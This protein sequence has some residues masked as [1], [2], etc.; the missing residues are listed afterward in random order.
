[1]VVGELT[2]ERDLVILGGGPAGYT[3]AIRASQ[4]GRN[5]TLIEQAQ[6]GGLC[7]NKGCIPSKVVAHAAD[8]K[9]QMKHM[10]ALGFSFNPTHD[11]SQLVEYRERTIRQLR[12]G[13]EALCQA[14]SIEIIQGASSFL[15][16]D[17]IGVELG[18]QFDTYR[19]NDVVIATG[20]HSIEQDH[21]SV[22]NAEQL[23]QLTKLPERLVIIG[24]DY[25]AL[26]AAMSFQALGTSVTL[27]A[28]DFG[29][30]PSLDKELRRLLK[31]QK[32]QLVTGTVTAIE[33]DD[34]VTV[35]VVKQGQET[36]WS[37]PFL[38]QSLPRVPHT[39]ELGLERIGV[40]L[41]EDGTIPVDPFGQTNRPHI[42]AIGDV[43]P[44]P[45]IATRAI[46]EAKRTAE[47]LAGQLADATIPYYPTIIRSLPPIV[48]IGLTEQAATDAGH[49]I[50]T[51]QFA[52]NANGAT[53]I[54][55]GSGFIKVISDATTSL[56]LGIHMIGE[57]SIELAGVFSQTLELHAKEEDV[58]FPVMPHPSRN[59]AFIEAVES[60][61]GQAIHLPPRQQD[62]LTK[63]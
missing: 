54:E 12:T 38:F 23:Y 55:G 60:L 26:E 36:T 43:T 27:I 25:I 59:E 4:L 49:S 33:A 29:L 56:I 3:A 14:N 11:F 50:R 63:S 62:V 40:T 2:Q 16:D 48:S 9:L 52:L 10:T 8:V 46:H 18:H 41:A 7:L 51:G 34:K 31:K 35:T 20:S 19:F 53:M 44:G 21:P 30:D 6:L 32:I 42:Y 1:M 57:G 15:A 47:H 37:A 39:L 28:D 45:A 5:V 58:R 13:V 22:L 24:Q 17:R 61:I